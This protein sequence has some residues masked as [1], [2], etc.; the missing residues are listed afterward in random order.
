MVKMA[1]PKTAMTGIGAPTSFSEVVSGHSRG[2][3]QSSSAVG[4][5]SVDLSSSGSSLQIT[6]HKLNG[7]NYL[8]WF[9][10][11]KLANDG[12]GKLGYLT[13]EV[14]KPTASDLSFRFWHSENSVVTAWLL[15]SMEAAIEKPNLFLPTAKD[16]W[17]SV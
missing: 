3:D 14:P 9:Q 5:G 11:I 12:R 2:T 6:I 16:V 10:S 7:K 13:G 8:E 15:N 17:D 4:S 1:R